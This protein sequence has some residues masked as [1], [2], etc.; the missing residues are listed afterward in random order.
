MATRLN[1]LL[2][3]WYPQRDKVGWVLCTVIETQGS[4]YRKAG[5]MSLFNDLGQQFGVVSGGCIEGDLMRHAHTVL[6]QGFGKVVTYDMQ[7]EDSLVWQLG[8][9]CGGMIRILL[10]AVTASNDYLGLVQLHQC[11]EARISCFYTQNI[12]QAC[13]MNE[14]SWKVE[15]LDRTALSNAPTHAVRHNDGCLVTAVHPAPSLWVFGGGVDAQ[16]VVNFAAEMSWYTTLVDSRTAYAREAFFPKAQKIIKQDASE[17]IGQDSQQSLDAIIIMTHNLKMDAKALAF[18]AESSARYVGLLGPISRRKR[19]EAMA[20]V[21]V[22]QF[23]FYYAGPA[24]MI[25]GGDLP[26][27]I[28]LSIIA[29]CQWVLEGAAKTVEPATRINQEQIHQVPPV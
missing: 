2:N 13:Q 10:Q 9:G 7:S 22:K 6:E 27:S 23:P 4:S 18:A 5:G 24:G 19:V 11:L 29:Q 17:L 12:E 20:N 21:D 25:L 16:P 26:E 15:A 14:N 8:I 1:H 28:A 3:Q